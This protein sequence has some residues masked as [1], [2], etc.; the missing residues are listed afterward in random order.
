[1]EMYC[2]NGL[3]CVESAGDKNYGWFVT[4]SLSFPE[5]FF[6]CSTLFANEERRGR[7]LVCDVDEGTKYFYVVRFLACWHFITMRQNFIGKW[8]D[9]MHFYP[10]VVG[11]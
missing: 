3:E 8:C 4:E 5:R 7:M 2:I 11:C 1:M 9:L 6:V 10:V